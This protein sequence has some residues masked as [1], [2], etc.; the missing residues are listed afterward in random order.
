MKV[1]IPYGFDTMT[2][3]SSTIAEDDHA[4]WSNA[5]TYDRG[6]YVIS[7]ATH[8]IYRS[9]TDTNLDNDPDIETAALAD[10]LIDDPDPINWQIIS[11]TNRYRV[12]DK[13]PSVL[14]TAS[15]EI[16][17][18]ITSPLFVGGVA[19]FGVDAATVQIQVVAD[20]V[21]VFDETIDMVD[22]THVTDWYSYYF[23]QIVQLSEFVLTDIPPYGDATITA[24]ITRTGGDV[25]IGQLV[26]GGIREFGT[27]RVGNTGFSG[28]DFSFVEQDEFGDLTTVQRAATRLSDFDVFIRNSK[29]QGFDTLM[30]SLRGGTAAVWVGDDSK[31]SGA[32][33][34]GF[35]RDYRVVYSSAEWGAIN[36]QVQGIV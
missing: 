1:I 13:K 33:N 4:A 23:S 15:D 30:K 3:D 17:V 22:N 18:V 8:T 20:T 7:T 29:L 9:L 25:A 11:A 35:Y 36:I 14:A 27:T 16:E 34:Y 2:L 24:T 26:I 12:F 6:D 31:T 10:P 28:L 5:T 19:G 32:V 21:T